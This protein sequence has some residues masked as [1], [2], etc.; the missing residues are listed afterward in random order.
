MLSDPQVRNALVSAS[1]LSCLLNN[2][3]SRDL[4]GRQLAELAGYAGSVT[5]GTLS[6]ALAI[7]YLVHMKHKYPLVSSNQTMAT[8]MPS[9]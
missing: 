3:T 4:V 6:L 9:L 5:L 1:A 8:E 2:L 7:G